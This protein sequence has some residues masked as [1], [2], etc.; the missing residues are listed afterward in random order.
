[1]GF[2]VLA[3]ESG[4]YDM[5]RAWQNLASGMDADQAIRSGVFSI[6]TNSHQTQAL[7]RYVALASHTSQPLV[8]AG[9]DSQFTASA[10]K[11]YFLADFNQ[12]L[13]DLPQDPQLANARKRAAKVLTTYFALRSKG[14]AGL[15]SFQKETP[16][17]DRALFIS[18]SKR[19]ESS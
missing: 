18:R 13:D 14:R 8:L 19:S 6:W 7:W 16:M 1:M 3:F 9:I 4:F 5:H 17:A 15:T 12:V 11:E 2:N 10:S